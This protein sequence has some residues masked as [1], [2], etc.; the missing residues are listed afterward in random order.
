[1]KTNYVPR[2]I[3][4]RVASRVPHWDISAMHGAN[5]PRECN[6]LDLLYQKTVMLEKL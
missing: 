1:M 5:S 3:R 2:E 6:A 4:E